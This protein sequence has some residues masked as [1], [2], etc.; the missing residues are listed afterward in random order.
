MLGSR[1]PRGNRRQS[2]T[3]RQFETEQWFEVYRTW[4]H[5]IRLLVVAF[6]VI[7][8]SLR[9]PVGDDVTRPGYD[10]AVDTATPNAFVPA[11]LSVWE[12]G[13][14]ADPKDKAEKDYRKRVEN[15]NGIDPSQVVFVFVTP[16]H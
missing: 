7:T 13:V 8:D 14:S 1:R 16:H 11:D 5:L 10:G 6:E 9:I 3:G 12:M 15:P 4:W 2:I